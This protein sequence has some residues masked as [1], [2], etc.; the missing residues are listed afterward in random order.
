M[1]K[2]SA[3]KVLILSLF[4]GSFF[5]ISL[6][7]NLDIA[8][9]TVS[10]EKLSLNTASSKM[11]INWAWMAGNGTA[12]L[13]GT[14]GEKGVSNN[15]NSPGSRED[16]VSWTDTSGNLWLFGGYGNA[17]SSEGQLNDLWRYNIASGMW[18]WISGNKTAEI[19]GTY[20][21]KGVPNS[22]NY[23][24]SRSDSV[25]WTDTGG[26]FWLFGGNGNAESS[27]GRLNDLWRYNIASGMWT[28]ISGNKT[29]EING[30]YGEKGGPNSA[31]YPGSRSNSVSWA[32]TSGN[33]W[34]FGGY[35]YAESSNGE[36][37]DLWRYNIASGMWTWI[38]GNKTVDVYGVYGEYG[39]PDGANYPGSRYG[40]ASW[41]DSGENLWLFGG[42]GFAESSEG[43]LSDLWRYNITSGMWTWIHG[44]SISNIGGFRGELGVPLSLNNP[45]SRQYSVSWTDSSGNLWLYGGYSYSNMYW[46]V[47]NDLWRFDI[48][49]GMWTWMDG[50][51]SNDLEGWYGEKGVLD[52]LNHPGSR[53]S[54]ASWVDTNG[55]FWFFGGEGYGAWDPD[56]GVNIGYFNDL[57]RSVRT[58]NAF[59][60]SSDA[61]D[62]D[63]DGSFKLTWDKSDEAINYSVYRYSSYISEINGS[64]THLAN[65]IT[66]LSRSLSGYKTGNYSFIVV[67][68]NNYGNT[69]SNCIQVAVDVK[70]FTV[71]SYNVAFII[72]I[73][74][75]TVIL[76]VKRRKM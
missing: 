56:P 41:I 25:S 47:Y 39:I 73:L 71:P 35:G 32:D 13:N 65:Q 31:N 7:T 8:I 12:D 62:P 58:P 36:L 43:R 22:A 72:T 20:G 76:L 64:L 52:S 2:N 30:T 48:N 10:V 67:A 60:L 51:S 14:Y 53:Y 49:S 24:G 74:G 68:Y 1:T 26:N 19:N 9:N 29:A 38:S 44:S 28:W 34:L 37:N 4:L 45:T 57:W 11:E 63:S 16:S 69:L 15:A 40:S 55:Q 17:E 61:G 42:Y 46:V 3:V 23:P 66:D 21:E 6:P 50:S 70:G 5:A 18:T 54:S 75:V 59:I 27:E 33:L